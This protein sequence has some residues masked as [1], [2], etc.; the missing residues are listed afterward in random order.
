ME[1]VALITA[2]SQLCCKYVMGWSLYTLK[3]IN[4]SSPLKDV[5]PVLSSMLHVLTVQQGESYARGSEL[6]LV[7][8]VSHGNCPD[9]V[10]QNQL[11]TS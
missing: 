1:L 9:N 7:K 8:G 6:A 5:L 11:Y 4:S 3:D 10:L 2:M